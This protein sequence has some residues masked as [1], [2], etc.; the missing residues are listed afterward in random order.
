MTRCFNYLSDNTKTHF[1]FIRFYCHLIFGFFAS[2]LAYR[3]RS[4]DDNLSVLPRSRFD[5]YLPESYA[6]HVL[7]LLRFGIGIVFKSRIGTRETFSFS[8]TDR[9]HSEGSMSSSFPVGLPSRIYRVASG[10]INTSR[11]NT[12]T[13]IENASRMFPQREFSDATNSDAARY[14]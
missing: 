1:R 11:R 3:E 6:S 5:A 9:P 12:K 2:I 13:R 10:G 14:K 7:R 8:V 4:A